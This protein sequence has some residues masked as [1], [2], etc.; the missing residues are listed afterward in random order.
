MLRKRV[1]IFLILSLLCFWN[2]T[3]PTHISI[4]SD[5][6]ILKVTIIILMAKTMS[7]AEAEVVSWQPFVAFES[8]N[9]TE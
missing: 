1:D 7:E 5:L 6:V 2:T 8:G 9:A 3:C 4:V